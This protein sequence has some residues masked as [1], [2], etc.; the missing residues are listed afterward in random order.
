MLLRFGYVA[1]R[2]SPFSAA[3]P[4]TPGSVDF[5]STVDDSATAGVAAQAVTVGNA[6][7]DGGD[8]NSQTVTV[9]A[10]AVDSV[11]AEISPNT[12]ALASTANAFVLDLLTDIQAQN[13]GVDTVSISAPADYS[14][15]L[16]NGVSVN[17]VA[18]TLNASCPAL[19][20]NEY[21]ALTSGQVVSVSLG[22][23][24][25]VSGNV[26]INFVADAPNVTVGSVDF[27][28]AVDDSATLA[29]ATQTATVGDADGDAGDANSLTVLV[30]GDAVTTS[31]VGEVV[32]WQVTANVQDVALALHVR[33]PQRRGDR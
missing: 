28:A 17:G 20:A 16:V 25:T 18:Q 22:T 2:T 33:P 29:V 19:A 3:V 11:L 21:C 4:T 27:V 6:D 31:V 7:G 1:A 12:I 9:E 32:P 30:G 5:S 26:R 24:Q 14:N 15:L 13:S 23:A 10:Q 8:A